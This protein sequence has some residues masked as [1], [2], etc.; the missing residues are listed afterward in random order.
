MTC[1][2]VSIRAEVLSG[3]E[4]DNRDGGE[5]RGKRSTSCLDPCLH[6][7]RSRRDVC[8]EVCVCVCVCVCGIIVSIGGSCLGLVRLD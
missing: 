5:G 4:V 2:E 7:M 8:V 1:S 3:R 6:R